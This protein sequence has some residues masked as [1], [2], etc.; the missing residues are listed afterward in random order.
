MTSP[1]FSFLFKIVKMSIG[2]FHICFKDTILWIFF[3]Y[4]FLLFWKGWVNITV[5]IKDF[6]LTV[7]LEGEQWPV[8]SFVNFLVP[9]IWILF[10]MSV[11]SYVVNT[12]LL[13]NIFQGHFLLK[14]YILK[15]KLNLLLFLLDFVKDSSS[16]NCICLIKCAYH[17]NS[18]Q[19]NYP[20]ACRIV[21]QLCECY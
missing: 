9:S 5:A 14:Q 11:E 16:T 18:F 4:H 12:S 15:C 20:S 2:L 1:S 7:I 6:S 13:I 3:Y 21:L 17:W 8:V 19:V 10:I